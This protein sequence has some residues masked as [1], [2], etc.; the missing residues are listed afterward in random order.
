[1]TNWMTAI[2]RAGVFFV[3]CSLNVQDYISNSNKGE[4]T[5]KRNLKSSMFRSTREKG[6]DVGPTFSL[7]LISDTFKTRDPSSKNAKIKIKHKYTLGGT[8]GENRH[9]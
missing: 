7:E 4:T 8:A 1:M 6:T 2:A 9:S 3:A 5:R